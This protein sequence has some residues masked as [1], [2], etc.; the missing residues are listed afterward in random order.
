MNKIKQILSM[1]LGLGIVGGLLWLFYKIIALV[2]QVLSTL[3]SNVSIAIVAGS[4]TILASTLT[5]VITR[6]YQTKRDREVAH[7][8]K[9]IDL[10]DE[11]LSKLFEI[12][13]GDDK[14]KKNNKNLAAFLRETQRKIILWSGPDVIRAYAELHYELTTQGDIPKAKGMIKMMDFFL[15][16]RKDLG[17]SNSG[18]KHKHLIRFMLRNS[19]LFMQ[20]YR[21]NPE[22]TL[23]E[24][25]KEENKLIKNSQLGAAADGKLPLS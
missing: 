8:D 5:V 23:E 16:L 24:I 4:A 22:V 7:R 14:E 13:L 2:F 6:Y 17:H 20:M 15:A 3:D 10:Y 9:K 25:S 21:N 18:I 12:F 1:L 11:F 19:D